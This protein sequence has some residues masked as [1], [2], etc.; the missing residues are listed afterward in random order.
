MSL[1]L[2]GH[3]IIPGGTS[4]PKSPNQTNQTL[5]LCAK[6]VILFELLSPSLQIDLNYLH[7]LFLQHRNH[8]TETIVRVSFAISTALF[9]FLTSEVFSLS[10]HNDRYVSRL[11]S[12]TPLHAKCQ[13]ALCQFNTASYKRRVLVTRCNIWSQDVTMLII[14]PRTIFFHAWSFVFRVPTA[15]DG[16]EG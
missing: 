13:P 6:N 10:C 14:L 3:G 8:F 11:F 1:I 15:R 7:S 4:S 9:H 12:L 2:T 5:I 16:N